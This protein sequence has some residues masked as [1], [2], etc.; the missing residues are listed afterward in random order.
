M[1]LERGEEMRKYL[2]GILIVISIMLIG[3]LVSCSDQ[4]EENKV[5]SKK[6]DNLLETVSWQDDRKK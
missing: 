6:K 4:K 3:V 5:E 2:K 1:N